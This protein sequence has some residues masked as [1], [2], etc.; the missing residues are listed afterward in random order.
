MAVYSGSSHEK[1]WF[2]IATLNSQRVSIVLIV[3]DSGRTVN[4]LN[5]AQKLIELDYVK[6]VYVNSLNI[7]WRVNIAEVC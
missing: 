2:S 6:S 3:E 1:W 7:H 5:S 4:S